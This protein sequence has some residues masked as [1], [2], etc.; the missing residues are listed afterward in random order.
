MNFTF[1]NMRISGLLVVV[2]ENESRY[3]DELDNYNFPVANSRKL[4][5]VIGIDRH[6]LV[7]GDTCASDLALFGLRH[8]I[9]RG[10]LLPDEID[11]LILVTETPDYFMPPTSNVIQGKLGLAE[12]VW[13]MDINQGCAGF[14]V[15]L[16]QGFMMLQQEAINR[17]VLV[18]ADTLT[19]TCSPRDRNAFP[20]LGDAASIA[21]LEPSPTPQTI[22]ANLQM[23]GTQ[24]EKIMIPAGGF[25]L[26][27]TPATANVELASDGNYRGQDHYHMD[28]IA[29]LNFV[30]HQIPPLI[31]A[32]L[33]AAKTLKEDVDWFMFH[34]PNR[35]MLEKLAD[36][37][38]VPRDKLPNDIVE[39]YG[40]ASSVT[41][42]TAIAHTLGTGLT[43]NTYTM[44]LCGFGVGLTCSSL[45]LTMGPL[46]FCELID[47]PSS[48][49]DN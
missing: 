23:D 21:I 27:R 3:D 35:F 38:G 24:H 46:Q 45:L 9:D 41:V 31:E 48:Q 44:C 32:L 28:G 37:L 1:R 39:H 43:E 6:R 10:D 25:R 42:P 36:K 15:G 29:V 12:N 18:N 20:L 7:S 11:G 49:V 40:N 30:Q 4:K 17:V 13:C 16:I 14:A 26:P 34:Q 5:N 22:H 47:F 19:R 2:P 33:S 8:L